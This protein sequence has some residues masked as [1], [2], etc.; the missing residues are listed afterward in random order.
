M[1]AITCSYQQY[2]HEQIHELRILFL[3]LPSVLVTRGVRSTSCRS[4][5]VD[6]S[7]SLSVGSSR[8]DVHTPLPAAHRKRTCCSLRSETVKVC[9]K[10]EVGNIDKIIQST[11]HSEFIHNIFRF[12]KLLPPL[13]Y[14][15][16]RPHEPDSSILPISLPP[17]LGNSKWAAVE[18]IPEAK[19]HVIGDSIHLSNIVVISHRQS[20]TITF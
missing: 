12:V 5:P 15:R 13:F 6:Q 14:S 1:W 10:R 16:H 2:K 18:L 8:Q 17:S 4:R 9:W 3:L 11:N 7:K 19:P 20:L